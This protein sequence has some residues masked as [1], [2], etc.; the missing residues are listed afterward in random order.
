M[1]YMILGCS[2]I[3]GL[4]SDFFIAREG[5]D[6]KVGTICF[7]NKFL[8]LPL[9]KSTMFSYILSNV[10]TIWYTNSVFMF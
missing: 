9:V 10:L 5:Q 2:E 1:V 8:A 6:T 7:E 3:H 4:I